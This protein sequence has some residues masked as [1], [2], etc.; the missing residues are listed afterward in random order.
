MDP[1]ILTVRDRGAG[2]LVLDTPRGAVEVCLRGSPD[3]S[4]AILMIGRDD[5]I[6]H[7][8]ERQGWSVL[9]LRPRLA[10]LGEAVH[11]VLAGIRFLVGCGALQIGLVGHSFGGEVAIQAA[12]ISRDVSAVVALGARRLSTQL[13]DRPLLVVPEERGERVPALVGDFL[14]DGFRASSRATDFPSSGPG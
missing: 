9:R 1:R 12:A 8:L 13:A 14:R 4:C 11:D 7:E 3:A 2:E 5:A 6:E 10:E